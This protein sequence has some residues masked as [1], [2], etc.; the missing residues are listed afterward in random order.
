M[1]RPEGSSWDFEE[2][3]L[4]PRSASRLVW[5][6]PN[7]AVA[8]GMVRDVLSDAG[9][10]RSDGGETVPYQS[11]TVLA[12]GGRPPAFYRQGPPIEPPGTPDGSLTLRAAWCHDRA[13]Q[14]DT[15][16]W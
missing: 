3:A 16:V 2:A 11:D 10:R 7:R 12:A 4:G 6:Q 8:D 13:D 14:R 1:A 9:R 5:K 15:S